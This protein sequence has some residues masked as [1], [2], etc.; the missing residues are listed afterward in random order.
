MLRIVNGRLERSGISI[1]AGT[2]VDATVIAVPPP[3]RRIAYSFFGRIAPGVRPRLRKLIRPVAGTRYA[4]VIIVF[5][6]CTTTH[7][8]V[9][10]IQAV[11]SI[12]LEKTLTSQGVQRKDSGR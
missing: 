6:L 11:V 4:T 8:L 7:T 2:I 3:K 9:S 5:L 12:F 10:F 1:R